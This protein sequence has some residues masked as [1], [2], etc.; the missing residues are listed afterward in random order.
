MQ[1]KTNHNN[2]AFR[3]TNCSKWLP[4]DSLNLFPYPPPNQNSPSSLAV[5][6]SHNIKLSHYSREHNVNWIIKLEGWGAG[7]RW[8]KVAKSSSTVH[9]LLLILYQF[10]A[11]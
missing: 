3:K 11:V 7:W 1:I 8:R 4:W 2:V 6:V 10:G 9:L 5:Q